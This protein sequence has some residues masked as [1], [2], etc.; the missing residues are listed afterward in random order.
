MPPPEHPP[1]RKLEIAEPLLAAFAH[2]FLARTDCYPFQNPDGSYVTVKRP[3]HPNVLRGHLQ[4]H[5]TLG[6]YLLDEQSISTKLVLDADT[7]EDWSRLLELADKLESKRIPVYREVSRRGGHI[8]LYT[9]PLP[10]HELR[11]FGH[12]LLKR[13]KLAD[14]ELY[15]KQDQLVTGPGSLVRLP[16][17]IHRLTGVRYHFVQPDGRP[18]APTIREQIALLATPDRVPDFII[19]DILKRIPETELPAPTRSFKGK[20]HVIVG[21]TP[22][23]RIK[24]RMSVLEFVGQYVEL[25]AAGRGQCPFHDDQVKSFQVSTQNNFW[26]CY[27]GCGGGSIID[28]WSRWRKQRGES[29]TF[30]DTITELAKMLL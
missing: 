7:A 29:D 21:N 30:T 18:L 27:A 5:I 10:A 19:E 24:N 9:S 14:L 20:P 28:F 8:W 23:E 6:T 13:N 12:Y 2:T 17:G 4:G 16:F 1:S 11:R 3:L 22:S 26:N 25:D 15:P